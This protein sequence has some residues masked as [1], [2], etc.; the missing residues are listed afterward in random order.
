M[1]LPVIIPCPFRGLKD[2]LGP[3]D[4][5]C[6]RHGMDKNQPW[7]LARGCVDPWPI[8]FKLPGK[9]PCMV[10][11][12]AGLSE[13]HFRPLQAAIGG[14]V[15]SFLPQGAAS[16]EDH[17]RAFFQGR[18][19]VPG[20]IRKAPSLQRPPQWHG[21]DSGRMGLLTRSTFLIATEVEQTVP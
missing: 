21:R 8:F 13:G 12:H 9:L 14:A 16:C 11:V 18:T 3:W 15:R 2:Q 1:H 7:P 17:I 20:A 10:L 4:P 5:S 6:D 19:A